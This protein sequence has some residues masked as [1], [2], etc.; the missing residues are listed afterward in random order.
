MDARAG[1]ARAALVEAVQ[2]WRSGL[3][4]RGS[5][6]DTDVAL[7]GIVESADRKVFMRVTGGHPKR[8]QAYNAQSFAR[9]LWLV[10]AAL[11]L[12]NVRALTPHG[13]EAFEGRQS[14]G[15]EAETGA[16]SLNVRSAEDAEAMVVQMR[17]V[18]QPLSGGERQKV[19]LGLVGESHEN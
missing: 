16:G 7:V 12:L 5:D 9:S 6:H 19:P 4:S 17:A 10:S 1:E 13:F 14:K 8:A 3:D 11:G 18:A 2:A 15:S